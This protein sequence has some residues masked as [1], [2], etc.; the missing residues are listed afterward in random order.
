M[1]RLS[2]V[3]LHINE[4]HG[5]G[6]GTAEQRARRGCAIG[7]AWRRRGGEHACICILIKKAVFLI[8]LFD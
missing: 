8:Q 1:D 5:A 2:S 4:R 7:P 3:N 6:A